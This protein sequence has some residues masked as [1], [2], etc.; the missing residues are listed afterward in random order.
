MSSYQ[1]AVLSAVIRVTICLCTAERYVQGQV[2]TTQIPEQISGE[3]TLSLT[4]VKAPCLQVMHVLECEGPQEWQLIDADEAV[5]A[6]MGN[7]T[8]RLTISQ[9]RPLGE[10]LTVHS[11]R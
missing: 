10:D 11:R 5:V 8:D 6:W 1:T 3:S 7:L 2:D 4:T 9:A